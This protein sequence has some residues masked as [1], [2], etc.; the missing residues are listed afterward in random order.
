MT[1]GDIEVSPQLGDT[2][3]AHGWALGPGVEV[4]LLPLAE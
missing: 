4:F 2:A 1:V 3:I